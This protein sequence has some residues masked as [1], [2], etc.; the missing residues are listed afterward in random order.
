MCI[1]KLIKSR[2]VS[3]YYNKIGKNKNRI[4][5]VHQ[6]HHCEKAVTFSK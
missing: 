3:P 1:G 5:V 6:D 2:T 4:K